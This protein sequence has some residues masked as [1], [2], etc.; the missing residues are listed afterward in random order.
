M[1]WIESHQALARHRKTLH[2]VAALHA[3]RHKVIG[4]LHELWWWALDN[5]DADGHIGQVTNEVLA[6]AAGWPMKDADRWVGALLEAGGER[7]AGF[8]ESDGSGYVLHDWKDYAGKLNE[9]RAK[10]RERMFA[11]RAVHKNGTHATHPVHVPATSGARAPA[12]GQDSTGQDRREPDQVPPTSAEV[13]PAAPAKIEFTNTEQ[14]RINAVTVVLEQRGLSGDQRFWRK[15]LD[16]YGQLDLEAEAFKQADWMRRNRIKACSTSRYFH[17]LDKA[18]ADRAA[19]AE[20]DEA[21]ES[22]PTCPCGNALY[23][24]GRDG[25]TCRKCQQK[26]LMTAADVERNNAETRTRMPGR[27]AA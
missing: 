24:P 7:S 11:A 3:D 22:A 4:H 8:L 6:E 18:L 21:A 1:P 5:A 20:P 10:N 27:S 12:T 17:W 9:Q 19:H 2:V 26:G 13:A 16:T 25:A 14:E 23:D 15:V